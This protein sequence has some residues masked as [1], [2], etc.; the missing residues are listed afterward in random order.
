VFAGFT[1]ESFVRARIGLADANYE[2]RVD[3]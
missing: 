2:C 3:D 1:G